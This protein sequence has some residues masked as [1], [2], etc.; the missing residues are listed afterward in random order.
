MSKS[1]SIIIP[2]RNRHF[3]L[4]RAVE[5]ARQ[6][7]SEIEIIVVDDASE[8]RTPEIC[9]KM[10]DVRYLRL[11]RRRGLGGARNAGIVASASEYISFLDDDDVRLPGSI[12]TQIKLLSARPDAGMIYGKALYGDENC[13]PKGDFYP[14]FC[15][16]GDIFR[17]LMELNFI[18]CPAVVF[19][20][21]CLKTVG[22]LDEDAAGI[23]DW[24]LW[25]RIAQVYPVL[26][27]EEPVAV[28][29]QPTAESGQFTSRP[30]KMHQQIYRLYTRKWLHFSRLTKIGKSEFRDAKRS[31][32]ARQTRLLLGAAA[33]RL[34]ARRLSDF[35]RILFTATRLYPLAMGRS[36]FSG[37]MWRSVMRYTQS[38]LKK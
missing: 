3:L 8:D 15:P 10:N 27:L 30:E 9:E 36:L 38:R 25:L 34:E 26:A 20:R 13:R 19:R 6:A 31:F 14:R 29:R 28:W 18:P 17:Q 35:M 2:T 1:V 12:D 37:S 22:L 4:A 33:A 7:G 32:S 24:D 23:E 21:S 16:Q 11:S 5:S